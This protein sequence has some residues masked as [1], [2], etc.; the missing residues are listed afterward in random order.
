[1]KR[2]LSSLLLAASAGAGLLAPGLSSAVTFGEPDGTRHPYV[3]TILGQTP[4]GYFSCSATLMSPTVLLTAGHCTAEGG[5][6]NAKTWVKFDP[7]ISFPGR[8]SYPS[9]GAYLD[10][11][12]NG[13][14]RGDAIAHPQYSD[15][16]QFPATY[17]V[18][19]VLLSKPVT[20]STYGALPPLNFLETIRRSADN[21]FTVVGYGM[22]G[23]IQ[24]FNSDKY[25][26]YQGR[27]K[28]LE[29]RSTSD[30]GM[31]AKFS[32]SPGTGGGSCYGD[33]GGPVFYATSNMVV[34]VVS[35]GRT[36][37]IGVDYQFRVDT[38]I[39]QDFIRQYL[40]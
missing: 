13:W 30:A 37:C 7:V 19:V 32:N 36:P 38:T 25:E 33:S 26:R 12:K 15:F 16:S 6:A 34:S 5:V 31:S 1:M 20:M 10:D 17:D 9:L 11:P 4:S 39:A 35:W 8:S 2:F 18:G 29:L 24:P 22:Q 21:V 27:V 3:G 40:Q 28:L 23:Y 14:V